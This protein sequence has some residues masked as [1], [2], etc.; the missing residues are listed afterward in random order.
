MNR[1][2]A[3]FIL[4]SG[5]LA[6]SALISISLRAQDAPPPTPSESPNAAGPAAQATKADSPPAQSEPPPPAPAASSNSSGPLPDR[7]VSWIGLVPNLLHD[8]KNIWLFPVSVSRGH[9]LVPVL[10]FT[11]VTASL[12]AGLD[13]PSGRY[14][15]HT[16]SFHEF[17]SIFR[18]SHTASAMFAFPVMFYGVGFFRHDT[19]AEH[20][21]LLAGEAA[22][23]STILDVVMKDITRRV[24]PD[25]VAMG[26]SFSDTWF[27]EHGHAFGGIGSFPSG[28][29]I[30]AMSIATVFADR[31]PKYK[32]VAYG[33]AGLVGFTRISLQAH[34]PSDVFAGAFLGFVIAH[35]TVEQF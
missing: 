12:V 31:Y 2:T 6:L 25:Q 23:D 13:N 5:T 28:H 21:V 26:G 3:K 22:L 29:E 4:V 11:I 27:K 24:Q 32:W 35:Y 10:T 18:N 20:T 33:L 15:Q 14:F 16:Q 9:H 17:D 8:Q 19:Y 34:H 7:P 30:D 1:T